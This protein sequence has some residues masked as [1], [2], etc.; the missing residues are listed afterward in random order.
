MHEVLINHLKSGDFFDIERFPEA[1]VVID[2]ARRIDDTGPGRPN[3]EISADLT[4]KGISAP[5]TF[6]ATAGVTP[7]GKAA[8][9]VTVSFDRT[10]WNINYGSAR[11]FHR[12]GMHLVNDLIEL[13]IKIVTL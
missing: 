10:L 7:N 3:L 1:S 9:Q 11:F 12:I 5:V 6:R 13:D 2:S 8:A 4:L